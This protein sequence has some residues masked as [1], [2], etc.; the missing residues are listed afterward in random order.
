M[1]SYPDICDELHKHLIICPKYDT[2]YMNDSAM[3]T[4]TLKLIK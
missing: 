3:N 2:K 4:I 1:Q